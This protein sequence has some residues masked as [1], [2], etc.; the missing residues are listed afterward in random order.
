MF[1]LLLGYF[2]VGI[3]NVKFLRLW[4]GGVGNIIIWIVIIE[5]IKEENLIEKFLVK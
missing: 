3:G 1:I 5:G 4:G 2:L